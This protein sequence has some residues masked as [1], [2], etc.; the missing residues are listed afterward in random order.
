MKH[1]TAAEAVGRLLLA[2]YAGRL[3]PVDWLHLRDHDGEVPPNVGLRYW[4]FQL[5]LAGGG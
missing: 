1:P 2:A 3:G 5:D 4:R